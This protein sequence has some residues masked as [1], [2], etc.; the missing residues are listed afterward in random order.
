MILSPPNLYVFK[1]DFCSFY[2][3]AKLLTVMKLLDMLVGN[4]MKSV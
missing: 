4:K 2:C 1:F 3:S